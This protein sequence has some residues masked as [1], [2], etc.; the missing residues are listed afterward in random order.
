M[1]I[2]HTEMITEMITDA[3]FCYAM[4]DF[5]SRHLPHAPANSILQYKYVHEGNT[6]ALIDS[7][8]VI[9]LV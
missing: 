7:I 6:V 4:H 3:C 9:S 8:L 5:V 2:F 1:D